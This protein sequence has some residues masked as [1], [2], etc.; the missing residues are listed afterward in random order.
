MIVWHDPDTHSLP[1]NLY[2]EVWVA[3]WKPMEDF[4]WIICHLSLLIT[5]LQ[6]WRFLTMSDFFGCRWEKSNGSSL[7]DNKTCFANVYWDRCAKHGKCSDN[8]TPA[9]QM[10]VLLFCFFI[11]T[12]ASLTVILYECKIQ[13]WV[14]LKNIKKNNTFNNN[15]IIISPLAYSDKH[16][17]L[18]LRASYTV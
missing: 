10:L 8:W 1:C 12:F 4:D 6:I 14:S 9:W 11:C 3:Y 16:Q 17:F 18:W 7:H 2:K 15:K 5:V 13:S